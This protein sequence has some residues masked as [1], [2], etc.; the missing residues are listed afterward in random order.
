MMRLRKDNYFFYNM[1]NFLRADIN[2]L[3]TYRSVVLWTELL[4]G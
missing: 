2:V 4:V 1:Y 3:F